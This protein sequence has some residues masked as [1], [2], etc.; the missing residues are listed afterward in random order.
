MSPSRTTAQNPQQNGQCDRYNSIIWNTVQLALKSRNLKMNEWEPISQET[1][2][3]IRS[4]ICTATNWTPHER[5]FIHPRR[6]P[7]GSSVPTWLFIPG[8]VFLKKQVMTSKYEPLVEEVE[9]IE[10]NP[11]YAYV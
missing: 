2:N 5:M 1:L 11:N 4:F 3:T 7:N 9:L 6:S 10:T 8:P